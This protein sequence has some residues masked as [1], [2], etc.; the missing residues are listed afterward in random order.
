M[1]KQHVALGE[2]PNAMSSHSNT[3]ELVY[4]GEL[5]LIKCKSQLNFN[6]SY[7][8][9][10]ATLVWCIANASHENTYLWASN[11]MCMSWRWWY[12][13]VVIGSCLQHSTTFHN[14]IL[15][16]LTRD[17]PQH[18]HYETWLIFIIGYTLVNDCPSSVK[19]VAHLDF[20]YHF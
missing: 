6:P 12:S 9:V 13:R 5:C 17:A 18:I 1:Y 20:I 11:G 15:Q 3:G 4:R 16:F 14:N 10:T 7:L 8:T 2:I 19:L